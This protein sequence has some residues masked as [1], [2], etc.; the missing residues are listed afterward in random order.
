M[1][2]QVTLVSAERLSRYLPVTALP[3]EL[4]GALENTHL[5]WLNSCINESGGD[6]NRNSGDISDAFV[7]TLDA[8]EANQKAVELFTSMSKTVKYK[9]NH[10]HERQ[11]ST[12]EVGFKVDIGSGTP[13]NSATSSP[14]T[15]IHTLVQ[16]IQNEFADTKDYDSDSSYSSGTGKRKQSP[17]E[18]TNGQVKTIV[19]GRCVSDEEEE[20]GQRD[21]RE[22]HEIEAVN[23]KLLTQQRSSYPP[24]VPKEDPP[25]KPSRTPTQNASKPPIPD[26]PNSW[27]DYEESIHMPETGCDMEQLVAH[28]LRMR[29][30]GIYKEYAMIRAEPPAGTFNSSR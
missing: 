25:R 20:K 10:R 17:D 4:G 24:S 29:Q 19:K 21:M 8:R 9:P 12:S 7:D 5:D 23:E 28:I 14:A 11:R 15:E 1:S 30:S 27:D 13:E 2:N 22:K 18:E 16:Q 6:K 3:K 26:R